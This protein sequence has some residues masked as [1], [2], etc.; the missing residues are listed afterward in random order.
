ME[1]GELVSGRNYQ[2][3]CISRGTAKKGEFKAQIPQKNIQ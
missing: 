2:F 1:G 3:L